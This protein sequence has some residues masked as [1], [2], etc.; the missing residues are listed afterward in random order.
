MRQTDLTAGGRLQLPTKGT[1]NRLQR[2]TRRFEEG[3]DGREFQGI[4]RM[5]DFTVPLSSYP[6]L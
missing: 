4:L 6:P 3:S 5:V 2:S 1:E